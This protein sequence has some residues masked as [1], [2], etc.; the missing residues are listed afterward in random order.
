MNKI[1][2]SFQWEIYLLDS[3]KIDVPELIEAI[4]S[5]KISF[6]SYE[7]KEILWKLYKIWHP[8]ISVDKLQESLF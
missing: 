3:K 4:F 1:Y 7:P 2:I 8:S 5:G 6:A